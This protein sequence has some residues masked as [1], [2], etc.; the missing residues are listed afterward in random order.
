MEIIQRCL[1]NNIT[2]FT[3][4]NSIGLKFLLENIFKKKVDIVI[5]E[6]LKLALGYVREEARY[7]EV[8]L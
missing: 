8:N 6:D 7:A 1:Y 2:R 4:D 5:E 3:F